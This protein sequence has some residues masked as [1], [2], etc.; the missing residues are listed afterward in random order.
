MFRITTSVITATLLLTAAVAAEA[1]CAPGYTDNGDGTIT[2]TCTGLMWE[3]KDDSGGLHDKDNFYTWS[4]PSY[5]STN[6]MDGTIRGFVDAL[7]DV[8]GGGANCFAGYCDWRAPRIDE[9]TRVL[10]YASGP[11]YINAAFH[12]DRTCT[13]CTDVTA[14]ECSCTSSSL[15]WTATTYAPIPAFAWFVGFQTGY[16]Y[17]LFKYFDFHVRAVRAGYAGSGE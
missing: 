13:G 7:N 8:S 1:G 6:T 16:T 9:L 4:G 10:D 3:K 12:R 2:D 11:P 15:Y 14:P 5:G 17:H